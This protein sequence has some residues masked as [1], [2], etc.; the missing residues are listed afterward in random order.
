MRTPLLPLYLTM[1]AA[2]MLA[3]CVTSPSPEEMEPP[4]RA[5]SMGIVTLG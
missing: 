1:C 2:L 5:E 4:R 3:S